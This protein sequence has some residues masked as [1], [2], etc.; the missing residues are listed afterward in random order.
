[1]HL[2]PVW[3]SG[4]DCDAGSKERVVKAFSEG[5]IDAVGANSAVV[6][7]HA[8]NLRHWLN[9]DALYGVQHVK[10]TCLAFKCA[11]DVCRLMSVVSCT[12]VIRL[13]PPFSNTCYPPPPPPRFRAPTTLL[14]HC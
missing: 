11:A 6:R 1:M 4:C 12:F 5:I 14:M 8:S 7:Q 9:T 10:V 2:A 13:L 3:P